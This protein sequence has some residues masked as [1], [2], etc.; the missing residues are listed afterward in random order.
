MTE[1]RRRRSVFRAHPWRSTLG[2]VA[3]LIVFLSV[4]PLVPFMPSCQPKLADSEDSGIVFGRMIPEYR[5]MLQQFDSMSVYHWQIG[6]IFL[7]RA[8]PWLDGRD[9]AAIAAETKAGP[10]PTATTT[11]K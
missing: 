7:I 4:V 9:S 8:L 1:S 11:G 5:E 2:A 10:W 6:P 3:G